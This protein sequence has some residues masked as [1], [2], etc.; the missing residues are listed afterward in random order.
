M[1][2]AAPGQSEFEPLH[3]PWQD[4]GVVLEHRLNSLLT[5]SDA[6]DHSEGEASRPTHHMSIPT[7][8]LT[9]Q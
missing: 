2:C 7:R 9:L 4:V 6:S 5:H 3:G 1:T 8:E